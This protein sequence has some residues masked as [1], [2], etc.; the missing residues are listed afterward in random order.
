[1]RSFDYLCIGGGIIGLTTARA[2]SRKF[3]HAKIALIEK[4]SD[5][6]F[7][8]SG[9]NSGVLHAGFYYTPDSF[10][11][12]FTRDGNAR[13]KEFCRE[14]GLK[15][16]E[17]GKVVVAKSPD[18]LAGLEELKRRGD[19]NGVE[20]EWVSG[21]EL[22]EIEPLAKTYEKAL[23]SPSTAVVDPVEVCAA[24]KKELLFR[25]VSLFFKTPFLGIEGSVHKDVCPPVTDTRGQ[26]KKGAVVSKYEKFHADFVI[27]A[28]GLY[29]DSVAKHYGF[30]A[31][32]VLIPFKGLYIKCERGV[33]F[34]TNI[35]PV[36]KLSQPFLGEHVTLMVDGTVKLGPTAVPAFWREQYQG[37]DR[38]NF[39]E[40][41]EILKF[42][43]K[44]FIT[45][46]NGFRDLALDEIKKYDKRNLVQRIKNLVKPFDDD[47]CHTWSK[48][49]IRAQLVDKKTLK[50]VQDFVVEGDEHS[51]HVLNAVSPSF[52]CSFPIAEYLVEIASSRSSS[53]PRNDIN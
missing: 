21:K 42:N 15:L 35:Y 19:A 34:K 46:S 3:P 40:F 48:P 44:L 41:L 51:L 28:A 37:W 10:K 47:L 43:S 18:Q 38:F 36:P 5:V 8:A 52:T 12:K 11:A 7:H 25:G 17:C 14:Q 33:S 31:N 23:Y 4:E 39:K 20:L 22:E 32:Y 27:N 29:A 2:L 45:N 26:R 6:A 53:A 9:R 50:F 13:M 1:M 49:G 24:I 16:N 30:G